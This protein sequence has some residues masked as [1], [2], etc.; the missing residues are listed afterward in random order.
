MYSEMKGVGVEVDVAYLEK[1]DLN[2]GVEID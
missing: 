2:S 1:L